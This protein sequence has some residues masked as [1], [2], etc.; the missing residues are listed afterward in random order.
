MVIE[1][2]EFATVTDLT[3]AKMVFCCCCCLVVVVFCFWGGGAKIMVVVS[4]R[5]LIS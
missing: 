4:K 2:S 3:G 5:G 1:R